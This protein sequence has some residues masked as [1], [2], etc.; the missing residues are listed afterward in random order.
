MGLNQH[1][2]ILLS[3]QECFPIKTE[4]DYNEVSTGTIKFGWKILN[5][6]LGEKSERLFSCQPES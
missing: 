4:E 2:L 6:N 3:L 5:E 1:I